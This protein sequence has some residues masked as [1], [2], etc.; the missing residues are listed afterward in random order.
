MSGLAGL[1]VAGLIGAFPESPVT[2]P[3]DY[4]VVLAVIVAAVFA[5]TL[6]VRT[7]EPGCRKANLIGMAC[8][9]FS[10][11][12]LPFLFDLLPLSR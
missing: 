6:F 3:N 7:C 11:I 12:A 4:L 1:G 5:V 9:F 2:A 10:G 8:F